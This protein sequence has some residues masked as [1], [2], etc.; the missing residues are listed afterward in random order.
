MPDLS[1]KTMSFAAVSFL[2]LSAGAALGKGASEILQLLYLKGQGLDGAL[3]RQLASDAFLVIGFAG[4]FMRLNTMFK[5][6]YVE[7]SVPNQLDWFNGRYQRAQA[8]VAVSTSY[9]QVSVT[10]T[11]VIIQAYRQLGEAMNTR[12]ALAGFGLA[13]NLLNL[14]LQLRALNNVAQTAPAI[15][16][17]AI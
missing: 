2:S 12:F 3:K 14:G 15:P 13:I 17:L 5:R 1:L 7:A 11:Y 10:L 16:R 8:R 9:M 4:V 6:T